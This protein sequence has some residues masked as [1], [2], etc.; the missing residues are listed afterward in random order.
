MTTTPIIPWSEWDPLLGTMSDKAL[1]K[2]ANVPVSHV[3]KRRQG[4]GIPGWD[5]SPPQP[6]E[7]LVRLDKLVGLAP[8]R[9]VAER[10]DLKVHVVT[11]RREK[12]KIKA[13]GKK[14]REQ[15][16]ADKERFDKALQE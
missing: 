11:S 13:W 8:D 2:L 10:L 14:T 16:K 7:V 3:K 1:A 6:E 5:P 15:Q 12:L 4:L 9:E